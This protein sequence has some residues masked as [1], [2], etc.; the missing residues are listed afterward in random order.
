LPN[1]IPQ[2]GLF[3]DAQNTV[4]M[5]IGDA[6]RG[7]RLLKSELAVL[8]T[9]C[10]PPR[11][12]RAQALSIADMQARWDVAGVAVYS[13]RV[14]KA[15]VKSLLEE[16]EI[17]IGSC[18]TPGAN[19]YFLIL[20]HEDIVETERPIRSEIISLF[21]RLKAISPKS[22]FVKTLQGQMEILVREEKEEALHVQS[23]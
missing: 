18:R 19:G 23:V 3:E 22:H 1:A 13:D 14:I 20:T 4:L 5:R 16:H 6:F 7:G 17:P 21:C 9:L 10:R 11:F 2:L 8:N 15:S 12:G